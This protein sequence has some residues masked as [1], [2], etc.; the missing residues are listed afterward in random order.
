MHY[1]LSLDV[2]SFVPQRDVPTDNEAKKAM[3]WN[4]INPYDARKWLEEC[5]RAE[6]ILGF[7]SDKESQ[8]PW[9]PWQKGREYVNGIFHTAYTEWQKTVTEMIERK[10]E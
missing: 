8:F 5:C 3:I 2:R 1:L 4:S 6:M 9:E 10:G 7:R